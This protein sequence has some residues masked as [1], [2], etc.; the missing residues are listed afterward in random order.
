MMN[1]MTCSCNSCGF[2]S[3]KTTQAYQRHLQTNKHKLRQENTREDLF[4]CNQC[5]KWYCGKS[6]LSHHKN[7]CTVSIV[8]ILEEPPT[9]RTVSIQ[10]NFQQQ[11]KEMK[12]K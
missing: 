9:T 3:F 8:P 4:Q 11:M 1:K 6:G 2:L 5:T 12:K 7:V 10:E